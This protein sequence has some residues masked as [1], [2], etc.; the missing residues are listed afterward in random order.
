[1]LRAGGL[2]APEDH[3]AIRIGDRQRFDQDGVRDAEDRSDGANRQR[4]DQHD[5]R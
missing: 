3:H 5:R 2:A 1:V 4:K